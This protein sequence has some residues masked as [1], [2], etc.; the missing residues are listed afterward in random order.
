VSGVNQTIRKQIGGQ[1]AGA[2][3]VLPERSNNPGRVRVALRVRPQVELE[4]KE[5][6]SLPLK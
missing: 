6:V 5:G 2:P 3:T 4:I 1:L